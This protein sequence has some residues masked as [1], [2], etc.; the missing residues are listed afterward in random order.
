M[1][2]TLTASLLILSMINLTLMI[3]GG[4][5]ENRDFSR[6]SNLTLGLFNTFLTLLG[7]L[8]L[9]MAYFIFKGHQGYLLALFCGISYIAVYLLDLLIIFPVS[10][11]KMSPLLHKLESLGALL[12]A[13]LS[14]TA[15]FG[16]F[17]STEKLQQSTTVSI[18]IL[19]IFAILTILIIAFATD[20]AKKRK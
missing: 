2:A 8:S 17:T 12:G 9:I 4:F 20:A 10:P 15:I 13:I 7:F 14:I 1:I 11:T 5:V 16:L 18:P 19:L 6:Y 3:P